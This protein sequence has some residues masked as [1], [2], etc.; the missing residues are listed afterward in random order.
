MAAHHPIQGVTILCDILRPD[1]RGNPG[2]A[3]RAA[4][5]LHN[6]IKRQIACASQL[7]VTLLAPSTAP[8]LARFCAAQRPASQADAFWAAAYA[9]LPPDAPWSAA[10]QQHLLSV[11]RG[12]FCIG[13]ELPPYLTCLLG[14]NAIPYI[15]IRL[16][17]IRFMDD[18]LFAVRASHPAT[19]ANLSTLAIPEAEIITPAH[20][21]DPRP[22]CRHRLETPPARAPAQP[23]RRRRRAC[24]PCPKSPPS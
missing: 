6:A 15:D 9:R 11:L 22:P 23:A 14:Q 4:A 13:Y 24:C 12:Q 8:D 2:D 5:W 20:R 16:H 17:P 1:G 19:R 21:R 18:L 3:D 7:C 10:L